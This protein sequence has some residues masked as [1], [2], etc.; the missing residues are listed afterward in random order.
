MNSKQVLEGKEM[1]HKCHHN[2][3]IIIMSN[4]I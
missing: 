3:I 2:I 1:E 4:V